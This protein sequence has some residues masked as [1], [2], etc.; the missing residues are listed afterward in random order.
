MG[1]DP[2]TTGIRDDLWLLRKHTPSPREWQL[3]GVCLTD[4]T[5]DELLA[6]AAWLGG[7]YSDLL[8]E[9]GQLYSIDARDEGY[10]HA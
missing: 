3:F 1:I 4:M 9:K 6:A 8:N 7:R 10:G 2:A 5:R